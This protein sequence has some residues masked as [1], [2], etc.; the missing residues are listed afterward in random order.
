MI[1]RDGEHGAHGAQ[2]AIGGTE[3]QGHCI[4]TAHRTS[5]QHIR[6]AGLRGKGRRGQERHAM[7]GASDRSCSS[8]CSS[9]FPLATLWEARGSNE[10]ASG[11]LPGRLA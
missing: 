3:R 5:G 2:L 1:H 4:C 10:V 9:C 8:S 7:P 11:I 6:T